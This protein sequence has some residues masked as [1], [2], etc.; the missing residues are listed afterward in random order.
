[1]NFVCKFKIWGSCLPIFV[2]AIDLMLFVL[3]PVHS[4]W[5][6]W[7][8][9]E[10]KELY[11]HID[12]S[13]FVDVI[14]NLVHFQLWNTVMYPLNKIDIFTLCYFHS[15]NNK[16][17]VKSCSDYDV[18]PHVNALKAFRIETNM[19]Q[20]QRKCNKQKIQCF[21]EEYEIFFIRNTGF[22]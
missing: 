20:K 12:T 22:L 14:N 6:D 19:F 21:V 15:E 5:M 13:C 1:M 3:N 10:N 2:S 7:F 18:M 9:Y 4:M 11:G 16:L 17:I 8:V